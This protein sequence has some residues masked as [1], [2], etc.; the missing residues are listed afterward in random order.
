MIFIFIAFYFRLR[1]FFIA[2]VI[3][4][5]ISFAIFLMFSF[6]TNF[7]VDVIIIFMTLLN[8]VAFSVIVAFAIF[9][10]FAISFVA[11]EINLFSLLFLTMLF[12][13]KIFKNRLINEQFV[14]LTIA[15]FLNEIDNL[16]FVSLI[17]RVDCFNNKI[18]FDDYLL[19]HHFVFQFRQL[20]S[21]VWYILAF[22]K[23]WMFYIVYKFLFVASFIESAEFL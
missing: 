21:K 3:L 13:L 10:T 14:V 7:I 11:S 9:F 16:Y 15:N 17:N 23:W 18:I 6:I 22:N 4:F 1:I 2:V 5:A 19:I 8:F 12:L 20:S